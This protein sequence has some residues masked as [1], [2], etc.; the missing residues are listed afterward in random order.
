[1]EER[2][3]FVL[4]KLRVKSSQGICEVRAQGIP[5]DHEQLA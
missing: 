4:L 3:Q 5:T 1:M 2:P